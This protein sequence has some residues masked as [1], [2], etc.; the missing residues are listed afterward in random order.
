MKKLY[1][2]AIGGW[3]FTL[4]AGTLGHFVYD[5]I[6]GEVAAVLGAVNESLWEHLKLVFWPAVIFGIIEYFVYGKNVKNFIPARA[7]SILAGILSVIMLFYTYS[8][9]LGFDIIAVDI[10][11]F[12]IGVTLVYVLGYMLLNS[13]AEWLG[14]KA[15][16][17]L[18]ILAVLA[19]AVCFAVFT[20]APPH[21]AM[22]RDA[23]SGGYGL[24]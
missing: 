12:V 17:V 4:L 23:Q 14:S 5:W 10:A 20:F 7:L 6:G 13:D 21:I 9:I 16:H 19:V 22:F 1:G 15:A 24:G 3:V 8:G 11:I 18:T 2:W